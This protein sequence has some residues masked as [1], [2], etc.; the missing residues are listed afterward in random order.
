ML[1]VLEALSRVAPTPLEKES[2]RTTNLER[3]TNISPLAWHHAEKIEDERN[4]NAILAESLAEL[5]NEAN[6]VVQIVKQTE[7]LPVTFDINISV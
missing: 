2:K 7:A 1:A 4:V 6:L 3:V 5:N